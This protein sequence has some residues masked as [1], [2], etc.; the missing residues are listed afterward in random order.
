[1]LSGMCCGSDGVSTA[2]AEFVEIAVLV[3]VKAVPADVMSDFAADVVPTGV[4]AVLREVAGA[5]DVVTSGSV[6]FSG[7][8]RV[9]AL[10][11]EAPELA[12]APEFTEVPALCTVDVLSGGVDWELSGMTNS[13]VLLCP[14]L[15][16]EL[17]RIIAKTAPAASNAAE[18]AVRSMYFFGMLV[19]SFGRN[20]IL[21]QTGGIVNAL[22]RDGKGAGHSVRLR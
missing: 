8:E 6:T 15:P 14:E 3:E 19:T 20:Y 5:A 9:A 12:A 7:A 17:L 11:V 10:P 4:S 1:M 18:A 22:F 16:A 13:G 2:A 21:H